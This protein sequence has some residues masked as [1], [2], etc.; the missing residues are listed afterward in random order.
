MHAHPA[1]YH[2]DIRKPNIMKRFDGQGWFLIDWMDA[3]ATPTHAAT[4]LTVSEHSPCVRQDD[5][6]PEVDVWGAGKYMEQVAS[7]VDCAVAKPAAVI[8]MARRWMEDKS[9][10]AASALAEIEVGLYHPNIRVIY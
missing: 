4:H 7:K 1:V 9:M 3:S 2:R 8:Q 10:S 5:H 6:G